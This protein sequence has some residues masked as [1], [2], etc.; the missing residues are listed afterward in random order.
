[1]LSKIEDHPRA[2][3]VLHK[4]VR[5]AL[6]RQFPFGIFYGIE[7]DEIVIFAVMH[8]SRDPN[9]WKERIE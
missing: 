4:D 6:I 2:F 3:P 7:D 8:A 9:T 5:R 1:M